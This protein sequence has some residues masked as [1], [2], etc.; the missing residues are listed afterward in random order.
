MMSTP[1]SVLG[2][3]I[4]LAI[5]PVCLSN[6]G[7]HCKSNFKKKVCKNNNKELNKQNKSIWHQ[8]HN[9]E[10]SGEKVNNRCIQ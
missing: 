9:D 5:L 4:L 1:Y 2:T 3:V 7:K 8:A 10:D 6:V